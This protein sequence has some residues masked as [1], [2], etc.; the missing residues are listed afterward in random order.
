MDRGS[1]G[2]GSQVKKSVGIHTEKSSW[3]DE[4][5]KESG[6]SKKK[7]AR[8]SVSKGGGK[9]VACRVEDAKN[10]DGTCNLCKSGK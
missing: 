3:G 1:V 8:K 10:D 2:N 9:C 6:A 5:S 7:E 4:F